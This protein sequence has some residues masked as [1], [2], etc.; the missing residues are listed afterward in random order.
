MSSRLMV[1]QRSVGCTAVIMSRGTDASPPSRS[2]HAVGR[3]REREDTTVRIAARHDLDERALMRST[4][5][6]LAVVVDN[7][8]R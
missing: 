4:P 5:P 1:F 8:R 2:R 6:Q 3:D 7:R